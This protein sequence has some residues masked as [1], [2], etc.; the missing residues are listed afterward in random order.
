MAR[1]K[2]TVFNQNIAYVN[3][4]VIISYWYGAVVDVK[5]FSV[6]VNSVRVGTGGRSIDRDWIKF[7]EVGVKFEIVVG[8]IF[9]SD[10]L[11][12]KTVD[13]VEEN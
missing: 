10:A 13:A 8:W 9:E 11:N 1:P 5:W 12:E 7:G 2:I 4:H 3:C 6:E